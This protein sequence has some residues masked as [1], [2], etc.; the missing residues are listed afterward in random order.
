MRDWQ[1]FKFHRSYFSGGAASGVRYELLCRIQLMDAVS[2]QELTL[3][4]TTEHQGEGSA[5]GNVSA[6]LWLM[7]DSV[8]II[9]LH[10]LLSTRPFYQLRRF[11]RRV[12][13]RTGWRW[14]LCHL[15]PWKMQLQAELLSCIDKQPSRCVCFS[16]TTKK[17]Y[18]HIIT[19]HKVMRTVGLLQLFFLHFI[20]SCNENRKLS[21]FLVMIE[22][23]TAQE[24][25]KNTRIWRYGMMK[26]HLHT[27]DL[28]C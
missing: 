22:V 16:C 6:V 28:Q 18:H 8:Q 24:I 11:I 17:K 15:S 5:V 27:D 13:R 20:V 19:H 7:N 21:V 12:N 26:S 14:P 9:E 10:V 23:R 3:G 4:S 25:N 1:T 2:R